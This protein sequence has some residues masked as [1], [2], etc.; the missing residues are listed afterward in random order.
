MY[1]CTLA[2]G[3]P[4]GAVE[5]PATDEDLRVPPN[6]QSAAGFWVSYRCW[7]DEFPR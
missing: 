6:G 1:G 2:P 4:W 5:Y 3:G 7:Y